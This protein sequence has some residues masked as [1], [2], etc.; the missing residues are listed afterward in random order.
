LKTIHREGP[1]DPNAYRSEKIARAKKEKQIEAKL[2]VRE[3]KQ[4]K[5]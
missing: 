3:Q 1:I 2:K 5:K 4:N